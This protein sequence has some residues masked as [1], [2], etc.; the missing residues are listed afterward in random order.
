MKHAVDDAARPAVA[1]APAVS[2]PSRQRRASSDPGEPLNLTRLRTRAP[3]P[4]TISPIKKSR[5]QSTSVDASLLLDQTHGRRLALLTAESKIVLDFEESPSVTATLAAERDELNART[6]AQWARR[7]Y[8]MYSAPRCT[9]CH[10]PRT[11]RKGWDEKNNRHTD[12]D[13]NE[14]RWRV[15]DMFC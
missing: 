7:K 2:R 11:G 15:I 12:R 10:F 14:N 9:A 4:T 3:R 5:L 1:A 8:L 6:P 13:C